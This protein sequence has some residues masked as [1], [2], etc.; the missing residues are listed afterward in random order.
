MATAHQI[1]N[2]NTGA[3]VLLWD[4][5]GLCL[6]QKRLERGPVASLWR[7]DEQETFEMTLSELA[8]FLEGRKR[9]AFSRSS[10]S[11]AWRSRS[12]S[13]SVARFSNAG[14]RGGTV[15]ELAGRSSEGRAVRH[16]AT[17]CLRGRVQAR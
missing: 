3:K 8:L 5:T 4:G 15:S 1:R 2:P 12:M 14:S 13:I 10:K 11:A 9:R 7:R 6:Y 17:Y 16:R